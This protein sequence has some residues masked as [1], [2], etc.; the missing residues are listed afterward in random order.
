[1]TGWYYH[2]E[3]ELASILNTSVDSLTSRGFRYFQGTEELLEMH[4][5]WEDYIIQIIHFLQIVIIQYIVI[6]VALIFNSVYDCGLFDTLFF[7]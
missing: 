1:M 3:A 7:Y 5:S 6:S 4:L 2:S